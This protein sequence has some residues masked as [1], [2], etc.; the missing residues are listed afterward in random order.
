MTKEG[1]REIRSQLGKLPLF[2]TSLADVK[3]EVDAEIAFGI[4]VPVP[5]DY[6]G[7]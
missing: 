2:D 4:V 1:V 6:S 3:T 5:K 7:R